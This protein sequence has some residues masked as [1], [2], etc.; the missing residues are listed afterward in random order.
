MNLPGGTTGAAAA[1]LIAASLAIP[2]DGTAQTRLGTGR[3][4]VAR[5]GMT[6]PNFA[7]TVVLLLDHG[8]DG[9]VGVIVNRPTRL[10]LTEVLP[11]VDGLAERPEV[12]FSGGPVAV[13]RMIFVLRTEAP[14]AG[15]EP[16]LEDICAGAS[17]E[18][19]TG[20]LENDSSD[21]RGFAGYAG[22][23]SGQLEWE[24]EQQGWYVLRGDSARIFDGSGRDLWTDLVRIAESPVA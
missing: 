21:F 11:Q 17:I 9:A 19:L 8:D 18:L 10:P 4:L 23:A 13:D 24:L 3:L 2:P 6:D 5:P 20:A 22:W 1:L 12:V 7:E 16:V 14:P 15:C